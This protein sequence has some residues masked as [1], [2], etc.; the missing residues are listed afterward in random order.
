M[1]F[2]L[3]LFLSVPIVAG[4]QSQIDVLHY[5]FNLELNDLN[6]TIYGKADILVKFTEPAQWV[7]FDLV[8]ETGEGK[9]MYAYGGGGKN[10]RGLQR[11]A[12]EK[13]IRLHLSAPVKKGDTATY[14]ILYK[15]I[16][17]D[18]LIIAKNKYGK[19][20]FF[21]DNWPDRGQNWLPCHDDPADK[22]T[23]EFL[24]TAPQ[25]YQVV[26]NGL[27]VEETNLPGN[28]KITHWVENVPISTKVMVIGV[29]EFAVKLSGL[30]DNCIP[31]YSWVYPEDREKGFFDYAQAMD[32]LPF[33]IKNIGPYPYKKLANVQSK[34][35]F[36]GLENAN[37]IFYSESSVSGTRASESLLAHELAHQWF[38]NHA[39][40]KSFAHL[41]LSEGFATY[42]T[43]LYMEDKYGKDTANKMLTDDRDEVI[44]FAR[45]SR[46][47][48][49]DS[50]ETDY[51]GL[52]N[53]NS[54]EKG[55]W[56]LHMLRSELG[57]SVFWKSIRHYYQSYA[58][59]IAG[60]DDLRASFEEVSGKKLAGFF[61]QWLYTAGIPRLSIH[62]KYNEAGKSADFKIEQIQP[63]LF[64]F[65]LEISVDGSQ[66]S[67]RVEITGK[68][69][70]F[71]IPVQSRPKN[72]QVDP[73]IKLL[74]EATVKETR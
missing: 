42:L 48:V 63:N 34:T 38:G 73:G 6:D 37:T 27:Q 65:P 26:S 3:F 54:Y 52:L 49:V 67:K 9:G 58:G 35:R 66:V 64:N 59:S 8:Q 11:M 13:K 20:S 7:S 61:K 16:P 41:W 72:I 32:I 15:G 56:V 57:D 74:F 22:A 45:N 29:A 33:Y 25:H 24:V 4:S 18:G 31:V 28:K 55:G 68:K 30:V 39:T 36:G 2:I 40:E 46:Q 50:A 23:V 43:I 69:T 12:A 53:S 62:W 14:T 71:S 60:T 19:R 47:P 5:R 70:S 44:I 51:M 10:T 17:A 21:A 1:R